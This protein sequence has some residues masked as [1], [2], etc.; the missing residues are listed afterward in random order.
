[1][2]LQDINEMG[3]D[4]QDFADKEM[5]RNEFP[6]VVLYEDLEAGLTDAEDQNLLLFGVMSLS[7]RFLSVQGGAAVVSSYF[8]GNNT[9][10]ISNGYELQFEDYNYY[11]RLSNASV[12]WTNRDKSDSFKMGRSSTNKKETEKEFI[13]LVKQRL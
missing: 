12:E 4:I 8:E 7:N 9:I 13:D 10:L 3:T 6:T 1:M 2:L 5:I 11:H